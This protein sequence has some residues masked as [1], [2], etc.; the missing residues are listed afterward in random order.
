MLMLIDPPVWTSFHADVLAC[1]DR[2]MDRGTISAEDRQVQSL[3]FSPYY[4]L[5][6]REKSVEYTYN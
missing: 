4:H 1:L 2:L 6:G 3:T 5:I